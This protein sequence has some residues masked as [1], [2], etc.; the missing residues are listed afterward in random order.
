MNQIIQTI[1][2]KLKEEH[3][4]TI[5]RPLRQQ[6]YYVINQNLTIYFTPSHLEI[7]ATIPGQY[8]LTGIETDCKIINYSDPNL[9]DKANQVIKTAWSL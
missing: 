6:T 3:D 8:G 5:L 1:Y 2:N 7:Y 9:I 4:F